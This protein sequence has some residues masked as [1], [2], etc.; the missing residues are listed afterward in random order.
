MSATHDASAEAAAENALASL[1]RQGLVRSWQATDGT[2]EITVGRGTARVSTLA[3][4]EVPLFAEQ[5]RRDKITTVG[6]GYPMGHR[7]TR[8]DLSD[9]RFTE[10]HRN[11]RDDLPYTVFL[12]G[13]SACG[14][15]ARSFAARTKKEA[16]A[17]ASLAR[18]RGVCDHCQT[19]RPLH[20]HEWRPAPSIP[21]PGCN[22]DAAAPITLLCRTCNQPIEPCDNPARWTWPLSAAWQHTNTAHPFCD[23]KPNGPMRDRPQARP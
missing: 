11:S 17:L 3:A 9:G 2:Y 14:S 13:G 12:P 8:Y 7:T 5:L 23:L 1:R 22:A 10:R 18:V 20:V 16:L 4:A 19:H 6:K 15:A 21:C